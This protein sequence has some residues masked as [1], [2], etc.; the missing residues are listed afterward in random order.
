MR[1]L[2]IAW[3]H[4]WR[5]P[6]PAFI[7]DDRVT[8]ACKIMQRKINK[9]RKI[10]CLPL[11]R[12]SN[13]MSG[14]ACRWNRNKYKRGTTKRKHRGIVI[15][16]NHRQYA[17][18][19]NGTG[20]WCSFSSARLSEKATKCDARQWDGAVEIWLT[21]GFGF[22]ERKKIVWIY[23]Q[24]RLRQAKMESKFEK[25]THCIPPK[26]A[27]FAFEP[28]TRRQKMRYP[29]SVIPPS[30]K[31]KTNSESEINSKIDLLI[32]F[33][34]WWR[35]QTC[36]DALFTSI[37]PCVSLFIYSIHVFTNYTRHQRSDCFL[38][39]RPP[40]VNTHS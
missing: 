12:D 15:I 19:Q 18:M 36:V 8:H 23:T 13:L 10:L 2:G 33:S 6:W 24:A 40:I 11:I 31:W 3:E 14:I 30:S 32:W 26:I 25:R 28:M 7:C 17:V 27:Y 21:S 20:T 34:F 16:L 9:K 37:K 29:L 5:N 4:E 22:W 39:I 1:A 35:T 38:S